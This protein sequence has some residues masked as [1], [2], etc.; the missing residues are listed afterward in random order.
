MPLLFVSLLGGATSGKG[1]DGGVELTRLAHV[2]LPKNIQEPKARHAVGGYAR[3]KVYSA[4]VEA[5]SKNRQSEARDAC[6]KE[7]A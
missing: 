3:R 1:L 4:R 7:A 5:H 6:K 2:A